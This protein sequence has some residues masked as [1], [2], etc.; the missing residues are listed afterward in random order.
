MKMKRILA[1]A[2]AAAMLLTGCAAGP[3]PEGA[4]TDG[5]PVEDVG[6]MDMSASSDSAEAARPADGDAEPG[7]APEMSQEDPVP[8]MVLEEPAESGITIAEEPANVEGPEDATPIQSDGMSVLE[9]SAWL[10]DR[11]RSGSDKNAMLSPLSLYM[12]M[13]MAAAGSR[14][15]TR[16]EL[17]SFL[18]VDEDAFTDFMADVLAATD[19]SY[20]SSLE[21]ANG[22]WTRAGGGE[23]SDAY[24]ETVEGKYRGRVEYAP[25]DQST[26]DAAN[27]FADESTHGMIPNVLSEIPPDTLSILAN[28]LYLDA[29]WLLPYEDWQVMDGMF[30]G[31]AGDR[32]AIL[33]SSVEGTY[34]ENAKATAFAKRYEGG[35]RFVGILP[36]EPGPFDLAD[37]D[38]DGLLASETGSYDVDAVLPKFSFWDAYRLDPYLKELGLVLSF[39]DSADFGGAFVDGRSFYLDQVAQAVRIETD[40]GGT[41]AAA[42]TTIMAP[43]NAAMA[44]PRERRSVV[45]DRPFAFII[46]GPGIDLPLFVGVVEDP[47]V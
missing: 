30:H 47:A 15:D 19:D 31:A 44:E 38:L 20:G 41:K 4:D 36:K 33:M 28:A 13:G 42:V 32:D 35:Y 22:I 27:P 11:A 17:E 12:A 18:G 40:E 37:L 34:M 24:R 6:T 43:A 8:G 39:Q 10:V 21:L 25:M 23:L 7:M 26:V 3:A 29:P 1:A 45:L 16:S 46:Q 14:G 9:K 5:R 2:M